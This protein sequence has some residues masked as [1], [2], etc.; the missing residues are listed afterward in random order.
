MGVHVLGALILRGKGL[1]VSLWHSSHTSYVYDQ[2][3]FARA[4]AQ[5]FYKLGMSA[6]VIRPQKDMQQ[7][8]KASICRDIFELCVLPWHPSYTCTFALCVFWG[9]DLYWHLY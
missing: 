2:H 7:G 3:L 9:S 8:Y 6:L 5:S 1:L 4:L